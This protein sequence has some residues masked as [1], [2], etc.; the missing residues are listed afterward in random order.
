MVCRF[1]FLRQPR[2]Y[3]HFEVVARNLHAVTVRVRH[4]NDLHARAVAAFLR[5]AVARHAV[6]GVPAVPAQIRALA[7][8]DV[9]LIRAVAVAADAG[10]ARVKLEG[11]AQ[12]GH[13]RLIRQAGPV[14]RYVKGILRM[15]RVTHRDREIRQHR[16]GVAVDER[17]SARFLLDIRVAARAVTADKVVHALLDVV[18]VAAVVVSGCAEEAQLRR[19]Q[20]R[21][22]SKPV[23]EGNDAAAPRQ[24][25]AQHFAAEPDIAVANHRGRRIVRRFRLLHRAKHGLS[26]AE[27][28]SRFQY[29]RLFAQHE[30]ARYHRLPFRQ[31]SERQV[32]VD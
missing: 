30:E 29:A 10:Q 26:V 2:L 23:A 13:I 20:E 4:R 22:A 19:A 1:Q 8:V 28:R 5:L 25:H 6:R 21:L 17:R 12:C 18:A 11:Q 27:H 3:A 9:V 32:N 15:H 31:R 7:A 16:R 24:Q 14:H